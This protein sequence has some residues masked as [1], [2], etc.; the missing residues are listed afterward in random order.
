MDVA[1]FALYGQLVSSSQVSVALYY[2]VFLCSVWL[3]LALT[4]RYRLRKQPRPS[5]VAF[6]ER[7]TVFLPGFVEF[8]SAVT[9]TYLLVFLCCCFV[10]YLWVINWVIFILIRYCLTQH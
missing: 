10:N 8:L 2:S 5:A 1:P 3:G 6:L 9:G 4:A 7:I